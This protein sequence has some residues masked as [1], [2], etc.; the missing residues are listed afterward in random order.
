MESDVGVVIPAYRPDPERL[1]RYIADLH[2][3]LD[4]GE[5][6]VELDVPTTAVTSALAD[7][8]ASVNTVAHR[9]GKGAAIRAGFDYLD[10]EILAFVDADGSTPPESLAAVIDPIHAQNAD[11]SVGSRR[12]PAA[13]VRVHQS[14]I[15]RRLGDLFVRVARRILPI[16]LYDYQCGAKAIS[17]DWWD[18]VRDETVSTGFAWDI[19]FVTFAQALGARVHE[20]P[21]EWDDKPGSTV[22][23]K[24]A[25]STF[26][27]V[28]LRSWH[29][30]NIIRGNRTHRYF[31]HLTGAQTSHVDQT[32]DRPTE[33]R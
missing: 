12:H 1:T 15:R 14:R 2:A 8:V 17:H 6:R 18:V 27:I 9:R 25:T 4:P 26:A 30:A 19:E 24:G 23:L 20:E 10:T 33:G 16:K 21:I 22:G 29:R 5:I 13:T 31:A 28:L 11:V 7:T 3:V 32:V